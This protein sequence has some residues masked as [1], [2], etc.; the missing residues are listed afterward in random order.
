[1]FEGFWG[2]LWG[3]EFGGMMKAADPKVVA[4]ALKVDDFNDCYVKCV[5]KRVTIKLNGKT[6]VDQEFPNLPD[7]GI[8]AWQ[9]HGGP[10]MEA[11]FRKIEFKELSPVKAS[12]P[13]AD[14]FV[15]LFNGKDLTGWEGLLDPFWSVKDGTLIGSTGAKGIKFNTFLC[16]KKTYKDFELQFQVK[17]S[18]GGNSGVQIRSHIHNRGTFSVTG[19]QCDMGGGYWGS[20]YGENVKSSVTKA[21][22]PKLLA[23]VLKV[24]DFNDYYIKCVGKHV[25]IKLNGKTTVDADVP[26]LPDEGIIAWQIHGGGPMAVVFRNIEFK[27]LT[28][29]KT[30]GA[31]APRYKNSLGMEFAL[32]PKGK[33]WL[34]GGNGK[35]GPNEVNMAQDFYL[36]VYEVTQ[37]EWQKIMGKNPS[38][39]TRGK[40]V[41][42]EIADDELKRFPV[43][44]VSWEEAKAFVKLVNE[45][46][47]KD[48]KE[49]G[50]EYRLPTEQQWEYA[51]RGGPMTDKAESAF[52]YYFE[53]PSKTLSKEQAN[54]G[55]RLEAAEKGG[56]VS[57]ESVGVA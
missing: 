22:D 12:V 47:K 4:E 9:I 28:S 21:A 16:S 25:T 5:G 13:A 23:E 56:F 51:C 15:P 42:K 37:E 39:F 43:E 29:T 6:T 52:D 18:K 7:D 26:N 53:K 20:L 38:H 34:G 17:L 8:I 1:M 27:E 48:A 35:E 55:E 40:A 19:P 30:T 10:P 32:V 11:V 54:F 2:N 45:K 31:L 57:T 50:W 41:G 46:V 36:G 14:G 24:E 3:E 33:S 49:A 44:N